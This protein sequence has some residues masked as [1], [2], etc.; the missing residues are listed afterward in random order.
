[1]HM[2][3]GHGISLFCSAVGGFKKKLLATIVLIC[4]G[5]VILGL[6][7]YFG[8]RSSRAKA[9]DPPARPPVAELLSAG[10]MVLVQTPGK[11]EWREVKTGAVLV[12]GDLVRTDTTGGAVVRYTGGATISISRNTVFTLRGPGD[13]QMEIS[14]SPE[15][16]GH[17]PLVLAAESEG[18]AAW[19]RR[20]PVVELDQILAFGRNLELIGRIEP[21][22]SLV[23]N[24]EMADVSG[25]GSFKHFTRSFP[26]AAGKV[27]LNLK[28][29]DLAQRTRTWTTTYDFSPHGRDD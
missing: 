21:G 1:M 11:A 14:A 9:P 19:A 10:G 27:K 7:A 12:E 18:V 15:S 17:P 2:S 25:D 24:D 4:S 8:L 13:N 16:A 3:Y 26:A 6:L 22:S 28:V 23:V 5:I 20:G 29:T